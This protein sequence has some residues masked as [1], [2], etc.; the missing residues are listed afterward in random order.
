[1]ERLIWYMDG[2]PWYSAR[3]GRRS[4]LNPGVHSTSAGSVAR[5]REVRNATYVEFVLSPER[6]RPLDER[7]ALGARG[8]EAVV[9]V[10]LRVERGEVDPRVRA[11]ALL[12]GQRG[13]RDEPCERMR[14]VEQP[15]EPLGR[16]LQARVAPHR[17]ACLA[18]R[19]RRDVGVRRRRQRGGRHRLLEGRQRGAMAED[20]ALR[21]RVRR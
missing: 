11:A 10:E 19:G 12:A 21:Q 18:R 1:M 13:G 2:S 7:A 5:S 16:A 20:E 3:K 17:S 4:P 15:G 14:V 8:D 9:V 6:S